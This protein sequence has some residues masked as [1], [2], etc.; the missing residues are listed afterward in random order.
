[1]KKTNVII[2]AVLC[3]ASILLISLFGAAVDTEASHVPVTEILCLNES[4][5]SCDV[6]EYD[7]YTLIKIKFTS[8]GDPVTLTGCMLQ[9]SWRVLPDNAS[10]TDVTFVYSASDKVEFV[11]DD[12]G[13][14]LGLILF[15]DTT[16]LDVK[17]QS[18]DGTKIYAY[19]TI[20]VY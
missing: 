7:T 3:A 12:D 1:M 13:N 16:I 2:I 10:Y 4:D 8:A 18:T 5:N 6:V 17:I 14:A 20:V 11:C 9:L 19:V 15:Y